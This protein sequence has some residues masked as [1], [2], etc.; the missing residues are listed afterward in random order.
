MI[1][2]SGHRSDRFRILQPQQP[3]RIPR[4]LQQSD[5]P[6]P[7]LLLGW[8]RW[9]HCR[10]RTSQRSLQGNQTINSNLFELTFW[11]IVL[12]E[13]EC[14]DED[15]YSQHRFIWQIFKRPYYRRIRSRNLGCW[16]QLG[17]ASGSPWACWRQQMKILNDCFVN[18]IYIGRRERLQCVHT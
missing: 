3:W 13:P 16:T 11:M 4:Y 2:F 14:L 1:F 18:F 12:T 5:V 9:L 8:L 7:F 6:W 17:Q 10:P 15:V